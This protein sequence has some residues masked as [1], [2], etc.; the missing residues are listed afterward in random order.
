MVNVGDGMVTHPSCDFMASERPA[1]ITDPVALALKAE[2]TEIIQ[3]A[4]RTSPRSLQLAVGPSELGN[5]CDRRLAY[6]V[7]GYPTVNTGMDP[8][9]SIVGTSIHSWTENAV[10][11][12]M[13]ETGVHD[14]LTE[15]RLEPDPMVP[16][17]SDLYK[18]S[19]A[20]VVD[21]KTAGTDVFR[22]VK[23]DGPSEG[24]KIQTHLYGLGHERA[25]RPVR[26][27]ALVIVPRAGWLKDMYVWCAPY[28]RAVAENA[29]ARVYQLGAQLIEKDILNNPHRF[30][31][32]EASPGDACVW[33]PFFLRH[34]EP[35]QGASGLGCPGR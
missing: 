19:E 6:R 34:T 30:Q 18:I 11:R 10:K 7:A 29:I 35:D 27:V 14:W 20:M 5:P 12:F 22:R 1:T 24:Y 13:N 25:G 16:G 21:L 33:C 9:P 23:K 31:D 15:V 3:W 8:W 28:E 26:K 17:S 4:Q 32:F 2:L